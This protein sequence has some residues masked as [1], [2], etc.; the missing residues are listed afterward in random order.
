MNKKTYAVLA[1]AL[2]ILTAFP[3]TVHAQEKDVYERGVHTA[4]ISGYPDGSVKPEDYITREE[5][6]AVFYRLLDTE[7]EYSISTA[8]SDI[9]ADR[10]S[11]EAVCALESSGIISGDDNKLFRPQDKITR[12]E[13]AVMAARFSNSS[14]GNKTFTDTVGHWAENYIKAAVSQGWLAGYTDGEF[15]PDN[16][17][18]RAEA[19][20]LINNVLERRPENIDDLLVD[21]KKW[22]DNTDTSKWYY[23]AVQ[24]AS[25]THEYVKKENGYETWNLVK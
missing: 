13:M 6:A 20:L 16:Y 11:Y 24:E 9:G 3:Q 19:M 21:M 17:I 4:Y 5:A 12:A 18:T 10:W 23:L 8:F 1:T 7:T 2:T 15:K 14:G 25:S 22:T